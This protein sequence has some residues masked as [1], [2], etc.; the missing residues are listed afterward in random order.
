MHD[1]VSR[2]ARL[3][4]PDCV[5]ESESRLYDGVI[6][7]LK[8]LPVSFDFPHSFSGIK[9]AD[10]FNL[11]A[12]IGATIEDQV[13]AALNRT[14]TV[15]DPEHE[16]EDCMFIRR[17][18]SFPDVRLVRRTLESVDVIMGIELKGWYVLSKEKVPSFRYQ[19]AVGACAP[20][21]LICVVP[22]YLDN[23]V[24]GEPR[25]LTPWVEQARFAAEWRDYWWEHVREC[26]DSNKRAIIQPE[27]LSPYPSK[28]DLA[29]AV[30]VYDTGGNFGR[31]P[32]AKPL[33]ESFIAEVMKDEILGIPV[34]DW[35]QFIA[36]H[37][38][39]ADP[40]AVTRRLIKR[41]AAAQDEVC[42]LKADELLCLLRKITGDFDFVE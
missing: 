5:G 34:Q 27:A 41:T 19:V 16:W 15:W 28:A 18:Q 30:P 4:M 17:S 37:T 35:V 33:M 21:D 40:E 22:W 20:M 1:D 8:A 13:V 12:L 14:R 9:A 2:P 26:E 39:A 38:D 6:A 24:S 42:D 7:A 10:L 23:A 3:Y 32:R 25:V 11:N 29:H 31:L 36:L